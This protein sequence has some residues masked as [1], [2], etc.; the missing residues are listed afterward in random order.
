MSAIQP[1]FPLI[2]PMPKATANAPIGIFDSGIGGLSIAQ[3]IAKHLPHERFI[4]FADTAHVPYGPR[5][6]QN[7]RELTAQA[8]EW[9]YRKGCKVAVV[10]CNTASAF[11]LDYLREHYGDNFPIIGLVP[12]LKPAVLQSK[13]KTVAV[14]ATPATF[15]GQLIKDVVD[16][17][18]QPSGVTVIP[19]TC[20]DL[21]PFVESGAQMSAA[22]LATLKDILQPV[23]DQGADYLV[24]GCTHYPFL[25]IAIQS[26]FGQKL[27]LIDSGLAVARQ[28]ARILIKNELLFEQ[29]HDGD[30]RIECYVSGNNAES[31]RPILQL[32]LEPE[33]NWTISNIS[34]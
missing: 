2:N 9:L 31:L 13:S 24:L 32:L 12:A 29:N 17:F 16:K 19:V 34:D 7:I 33:L 23:V 6:D 30:V 27:T 1:L 3:E 15:R 14:L 20:L 8:I 21:V 28:T 11:S 4:Y 10:A 18:A 25:K 5:N 26:I 22:C